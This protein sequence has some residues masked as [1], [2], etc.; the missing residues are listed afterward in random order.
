MAGNKKGGLGKGL[1]V[2]FSENTQD[3]IENQLLNPDANSENEDRIIYIDINKITPNRKQPRKA[4]DEESLKELS[5]SIKIHGVI[6]PIIVKSISNGY[7]IIAGERR[8]RASRLAGLK[9]MPCIIRAFSDKDNLLVALIENLQRENLNPMDESSAY[10]YMQ[11]NFGLTQEEISHNVG[12]SRPY[13]ANAVRLQKLSEPVKKLLMENRLSAGHGRALLSMEDPK[14]Q[15]ET[16]R[17]IIDNQLSVRQTEALIKE[18]TSHKSKT[19]PQG[20]NPAFDTIES[21]IRENIGAKVKIKEKNNKGT[22]QLSFYS[23]EE[24]ERLIEILLSFK[25]DV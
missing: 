3:I 17:K 10:Y 24:L 9:E 2:L 8:W 19:S 20:R 23:K 18:L 6:Q 13:I 15:L 14:K 16:A 21:D 12:K 5:D 11:E 25:G 1:S 7:E 4:F 22:I